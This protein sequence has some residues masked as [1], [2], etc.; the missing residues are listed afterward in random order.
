MFQTKKYPKERNSLVSWK[1]KDKYK[2]DTLSGE[3]VPVGKWGR[4]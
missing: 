3:E 4:R 2:Y 1:N